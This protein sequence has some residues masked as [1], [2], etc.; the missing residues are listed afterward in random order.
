MRCPCCKQGD[1]LFE[2]FAHPLGV[3][4]GDRD[5]VAP[6]EYVGVGERALDGAQ[7]LVACA[8]ECSHEMVR[9]NR[10]LEMA[11]RASLTT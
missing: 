7:V 8:D 5:L 1:E 2:Q 9:G 4:A 11:H 10:E 6:H 3:V